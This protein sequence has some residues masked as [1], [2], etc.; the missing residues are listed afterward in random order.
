MEE[1]VTEATTEKF[2]RIIALCLT[3]FS[4]KCIERHL[5]QLQEEYTEVLM[6]SLREALRS[7]ERE[8][9]RQASKSGKPK[10]ARTGAKRQRLGD[11]Q[12]P[13]ELAPL[14]PLQ[15]L[16]QFKPVNMPPNLPLMPNYAAANTLLQPA[17]GIH[18]TVPLGPHPT[19]QQNFEPLPLAVPDEPYN[20]GMIG[21]D[22]LD[23]WNQ[24]P[25]NGTPMWVPGPDSEELW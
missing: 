22:Q 5:P 23:P 9:I 17:Y 24:Y 1:T 13:V 4:S 3:I 11:M 6:K 8:M 16:G 19:P 14:Q 18:G 25:L 20:A 2:D 10:P 12:I 15:A 21:G 7:A